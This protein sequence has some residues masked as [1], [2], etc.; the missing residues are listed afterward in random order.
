MFLLRLLKLTF[1]KTV[2]G[3]L[4]YISV[5]IFAIASAET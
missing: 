3:N 5:K 4:T 1:Q 2:N